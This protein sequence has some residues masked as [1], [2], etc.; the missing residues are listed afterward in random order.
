MNGA[1]SGIGRRIAGWLQSPV[2][3]TALTLL[4]LVL[5]IVA[6]LD[7]R[8]LMRLSP[9]SEYGI[10]NVIPWEYWLAIAISFSLMAANVFN[11]K[12]FYSPLSMFFFIILFVNVES[13]FLYEP[14]GSTDAYMHFLNGATLADSGNTFFSLDAPP[15]PN[16]YFGSFMLTKM[17]VETMGLGNGDVV[18]LLSIFRFIVPLW[19]F[20]CTYFLLTRLTTLRRAR[21]IT[22]VAILGIPYFQFHYSPQAFGLILLPILLYTVAVPNVN[23]KKCLVIQVLLFTILIFTHG[24]TAIF[25][26]LTYAFVAFMHRLMIFAK[27]TPGGLNVSAP[28]AAY[29]LVGMVL[30]NPMIYRL[31]SITFDG[32]ASLSFIAQAVSVPATGTGLLWQAQLGLPGLGRVGGHFIVPELIRL[33][34][35]GAF[36]ALSAYGTSV[37]LKKRDFGGINLLAMGGFAATGIFSVGNVLFPSMNLGDRSFLFLGIST[38]LM[39]LFLMRG[40]FPPIRWKAEPDKRKALVGLLLALLMLS[41]AAGVVAYHYNQGIHFTPPQNEDR[42]LWTAWHADAGSAYTQS[43]NHGIAFSR[44]PF[45]ELGAGEMYELGLEN[46]QPRDPVIHQDGTFFVFTDSSRWYF[47]WEEKLDDYRA[48]LDY[49]EAECDMVY[50][51]PG[52]IV[53]YTTL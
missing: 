24:P 38:V 3:F 14:V 19:F 20:S 30:T 4:S 17:M 52:N 41:P 37:M 8:P 10:L 5:A 47:T 6:S 31:A 42:F 7:T 29:F 26:A 22:A 32:G 2:G 48:I 33:C 9:D 34:V 27:Q 18:A 51:S 23:M 36:F 12:K 15:Y 1:I 53:Y 25:F 44:R 11:S 39:M 50:S 49:C 21:F 46:F 43:D 35:L 16:G 13:F 45:V 40:G 28:V